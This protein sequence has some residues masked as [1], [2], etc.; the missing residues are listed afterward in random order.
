MLQ[1]TGAI[2]CSPT[3]S[4]DKYAIIGFIVLHLEGVLDSAAEWGGSSLRTCSR[5][6]FDVTTGTTYPL[7]SIGPR[8]AT[9]P[10][11]ARPPGSQNFKINGQ[12]SS[13]NW[14]YDDLNKSFTWTG[15]DTRRVHIDFDWWL[16]GECGRPPNNSSAVCLKVTTVEVRFG[17]QGICPE[18]ADFGLRGVRLCD[19][20][21]GSCP[22]ELN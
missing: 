10:P 1:R 18:C 16:D 5:N 19:L 21:I 17:G 11:V 20:A 9:A 8:R 6:N 22:E 4:P 13:P 3:L 15:P 14:T 7:S 2:G 12:A